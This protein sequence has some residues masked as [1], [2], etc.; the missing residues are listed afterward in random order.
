MKKSE[1]V[2]ELD[3]QRRIDKMSQD[4]MAE[5]IGVSYTSYN[6]Y[7]TGKTEPSEEVLM[8][9]F[10]YIKDETGTVMRVEDE[11]SNETLYL[12]KEEAIECLIEKFS[13]KDLLKI[14]DKLEDIKREE[15]RVG[16]KE[17]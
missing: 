10:K 15:E 17:K 5:E 4:E 12:G 7:V 14:A 6:N 16:A 3:K 1:I 9:M 8:R 11:E 13:A 2:P